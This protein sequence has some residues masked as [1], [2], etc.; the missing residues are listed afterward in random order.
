M[1]LRIVKAKAD[2]SK[3]EEIRN[4]YNSQ[5]L[6]DFFSSQKGHRFHH[7]L[8]S[9]SDPGDIIFL[10]AWD[11]QEEMTEAFASDAHKKVG[12]KFKQYLVAPSERELYQV[13]E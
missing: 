4:L 8:E 10:T 9:P 6:T 7:L 11:S 2:P 1:W 12:G 13:Y 5:E 3:V